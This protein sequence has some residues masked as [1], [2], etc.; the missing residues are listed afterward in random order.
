MNRFKRPTF[1]C[2]ITNFK[3]LLGFGICILTLAQP[4]L[5]LALDN[6][7]DQTIQEQINQSITDYVTALQSGRYPKV[8]IDISPL[9]SRLRLAECDQPLSLEHRPKSRE[10]GRLTVKLTCNASSSWT[11][12]VPVNVQVYDQ[13]VIADTPLAMGT[14][15][16]KRNVRKELRDVTLMYQGYFSDLSNIEGFVT[17]RPIQSGQVLNSAL[18]D[19][20]KMIERGE[21]VVI[22]AEKSGLTIRTTGVSMDDGAYGELIRVKNSKSN[23]V[24]EGRVVGPGQIKVA[25]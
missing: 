5:S 12:H 18:V 8:D 9:D 3:R 7:A 20:A 4:R 25:L 22:L 1:L 19:P 10:A 17:K 13:V 11:I 15:L 16:S 2:P 24:V 21:R 23:R 6:Q 14:I